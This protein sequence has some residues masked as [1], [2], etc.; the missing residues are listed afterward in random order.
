MFPEEII[1]YELVCP[2]KYNL[3]IDDF[4]DDGGVRKFR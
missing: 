4:L 2:V 1:M 3:K